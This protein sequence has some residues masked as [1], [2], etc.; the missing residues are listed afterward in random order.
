[1][2]FLV[3]L[4]PGADGYIIGH[5]LVF[6]SILP[7]VD[8]ANRPRRLIGPSLGSFGGFITPDSGPITAGT[9]SQPLTVLLG[10]QPPVKSYFSSRAR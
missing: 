9:G 2:K 6:S 8:G 10:W 3:T 4:E 5:T 1:M 7:P